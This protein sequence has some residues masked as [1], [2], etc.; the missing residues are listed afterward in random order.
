LVKSLRSS[1][2]VVIG[3]LDEA[4]EK[5]RATRDTYGISY[6]SVPVGTPPEALGPVIDRLAGT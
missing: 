5:F 3:T 4:C 2:L 6:W 1:P